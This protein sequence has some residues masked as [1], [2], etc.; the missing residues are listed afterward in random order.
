MDVLSVAST[1]ALSTQAQSAS[2]TQN[3]TKAAEGTVPFQQQLNQYAMQTDSKETNTATVAVSES[4]A[5]SD[6]QLQLTQL[7][8]DELLAMI[9]GLIEQLE[10]LNDVPLTE[11]NQ[12]AL[13][14]ASLQ[15]MALLQL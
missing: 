10:Q 5:I 15:L 4:T 8:T 7:N 11:D 3:T 2:Q 13:D 1:V 6:V 14:A 12:A 9:E